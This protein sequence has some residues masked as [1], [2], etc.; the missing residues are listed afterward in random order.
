MVG[1]ARSRGEMYTIRG[2]HKM[3]YAR[4]SGSLRLGRYLEAP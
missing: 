2:R 3:E 4:R 1:A